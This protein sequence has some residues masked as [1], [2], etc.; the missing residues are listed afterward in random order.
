MSAF[1]RAASESTTMLRRNLRHTLRYPTTIVISLVTPTILLLL[2]V[3]V[4]GGALSAGVGIG[5]QGGKYID[6]MAP[7]SLLLTL[8][9]G[10]STTAVIVN[11]D[12]TEGIIARFRTMPISRAAVST[13]HVLEA[14]IRMMASGG[15]VMGVAVLMGFR[16]A[17]GPVGWLAA[18]GVLAMFAFSLTCVAVAVGLLAKRSE[19]TVP[20][21]IA[22]QILPL[23]SSAFAPTETMPGAVAWFASHEPFTPVTDTLRGLLMGTPVGDSVTPAVA[24]CAGFV[25]A[26]YL[27]ARAWFKRDPVR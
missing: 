15:L 11:R 7:G 8:C 27:W 14:M 1:S 4:F 24:W 13:G 20:F 12:M 26:G 9:Y 16:P 2:F 10:A 22:V 19:G 6:Y 25:L 23:I 3:N 18:I 5:S 21:G 17:A